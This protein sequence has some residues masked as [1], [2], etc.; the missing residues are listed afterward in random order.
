MA[1]ASTLLSYD[2]LFYT[3]AG[4]PVTCE[5]VPGGGP[6][7]NYGMLLRLANGDVL[8]IYSD[9]GSGS[10]I[11]GAAVASSTSILDYEDTYPGNP[12][13]SGPA[14][15]SLLTFAAAP[16]P[17]TWTMMMLGFAGVGFAGYRASRKSAAVAA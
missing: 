9:G 6:L 7:D 3:G 2:N 8:D 15:S 17:S 16:E 11:F 13:W 14:A 4:S 10:T 1:Y 12:D 5:G